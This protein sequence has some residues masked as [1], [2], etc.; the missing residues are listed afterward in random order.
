VEYV[1][2]WR[3]M[4]EHGV[5][6]TAGA[7]CLVIADDSMKIITYANRIA[8]GLGIPLENWIPD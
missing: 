1:F 8:D 2:E 3:A 5:Y 6:I 4:V 7:K